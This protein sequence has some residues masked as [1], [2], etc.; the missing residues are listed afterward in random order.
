MPAIHPKAVVLA[1]KVINALE[2]AIEDCSL[3]IGAY[4]TSEFLKL[5]IIE[6]KKEEKRFKLAENYLEK[7][8]EG[9]TRGKSRHTKN[10][11]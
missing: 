3:V 8:S 1:R 7:N 9:F 11:K 10:H 6:L 2:T 4:Y 5:M